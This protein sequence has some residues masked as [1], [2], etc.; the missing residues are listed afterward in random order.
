M[1]QNNDNNV[2]EGRTDRDSSAQERLT[3]HGGAGQESNARRSTQQRAG[4]P[5]E[6]TQ[7]P[8]QTGTLGSE[9][10]ER[11]GRPGLYSGVGGDDL[12]PLGGPELSSGPGAMGRGGEAGGMLVG[13][14]HPMF[15]QGMDDYDEDYPRPG[16]LGGPERLP[17]DAAP[18][19]ARFDPVTPFGPMPGRGRGG[20]GGRGRGR[21]AGGPFGGDPDNDM[22]MPPGGGGFG[23]SG[24]DSFL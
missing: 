21:G 15:G 5:E 2:T 9:G 8:H 11:H 14:D 7:T 1:S 13:P 3:A 16:P 12:I 19:G 18:P 4:G 22:F 24:P 10:L 20:R 6:H 17:R 23:G